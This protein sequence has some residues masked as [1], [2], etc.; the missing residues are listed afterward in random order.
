M[1][2][3]ANLVVE[4][5]K[6]VDMVGSG[7]A[8]CGALFISDLLIDEM[9]RSHGNRTRFSGNHLTRLLFAVRVGRVVF[10]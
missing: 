10:F 1:R 9:D 6:L 5:K 3:Q 8:S 4:R 7:L 2:L